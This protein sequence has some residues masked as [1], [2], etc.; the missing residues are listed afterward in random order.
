M[1]ETWVRSPGEGKGYP[2]QYSGL[3]TVHGVAESRTRLS[4]LHFHLC[5]SGMKDAD[6]SHLSVVLVRLMLVAQSC[7]ILCHPM[8]CSPPGSSD[9]G[10]LQART[11]EWV[12][13]PSSRGSSRPRDRTQV[14]SM[15]GRF[16]TIRE[17]SQYSFVCFLRKNQVYTVAYWLLL[18]LC[19]PVP[20]LI[21]SC[22]N[23]PIGTLGR[24]R[25]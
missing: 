6:I 18:R 3:E 24:S 21:S 12:A 5:F 14:P 2:L 7:P 19:I 23:L 15:A 22:L 16:L 1:W 13:M 11:L 10:I 9:R 17:P 4:D 25:R 8:D 20:S